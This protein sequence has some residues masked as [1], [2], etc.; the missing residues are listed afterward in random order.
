[1]LD[2]KA[3]SQVFQLLLSKSKCFLVCWRLRFVRSFKARRTQLWKTFRIRRYE[4]FKRVFSTNEGYLNFYL[5][6]LTKCNEQVFLCSGNDLSFR[7]HVCLQ[8]SVIIFFDARNERISLNEEIKSRNR[9]MCFWQV[10]GIWGT[11]YT[12]TLH[13]ISLYL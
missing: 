11:R 8:P 6:K 2:I 9:K 4:L 7:A 13:I 1:M 3:K 5:H 12:L 10:S